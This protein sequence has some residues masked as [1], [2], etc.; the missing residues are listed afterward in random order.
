[1]CMCRVE[2]KIDEINVIWYNMYINKFSELL[3]ELTK[4][5]GLRNGLNA[6][7]VDNTLSL[8]S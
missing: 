5:V 4:L 1:M 2:N 7:P 8:I 3:R 6:Q